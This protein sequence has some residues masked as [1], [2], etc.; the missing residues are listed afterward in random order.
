VVDERQK[1]D[2]PP[3]ITWTEPEVWSVFGEDGSYFGEFAFPIDTRLIGFGPGV[4]WA[5]R[6]IGDGFEVARL[7]II[8][9][10]N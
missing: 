4:L 3:E 10:S 2:S 9:R 7:R 1:S 5:A 6:K 8:P